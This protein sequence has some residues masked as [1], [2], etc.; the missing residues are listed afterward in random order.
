MRLL[1]HQ[2]KRL[3]AQYGLVFTVA[4]VV[5]TAAGA[6]EAAARIGATVVLK[7]QVPFGGRGKAGAVKVAATP[8][9]AQAA[10]AA[11]LQMT[12]RSHRVTQV[13]VEPKVAIRRELYAGVSWDTSAKLP[14]VLAGL[15]G[16][17]DVEALGAIQRRTFDP[18]AGLSAEA[19]CELAARLGLPAGLVP[20][21]GAVLG[22]LSHAFLD[23][24]GVTVE[25]NPLVETADGALVGLDARVELDD[26]AA[27]RQQARLAP[28][29]PIP[30]GSTGRPPTPLEEEARRIDAT[31]HRGVAGRVVEFDG[32][33][34]LLI[35]GGG[36]SLTV[37][38]AVRRHGG[39]P[40][41]YCEVG[42]NPTEEKVA[43]L[44]ALLLS[45]PG[46]R[47]LAVIMNVVNNTR[48]DVMA[49]GVLMGLER[50]GRPAA[51]TIAVFRIP[52]SWEQEARE[53][54]ARAGVTALGRDV[55]LD[56]AARRAVN[57]AA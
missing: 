14:V 10:A 32:D 36:A 52:G 22:K 1:E 42:G 6:G 28:L 23:C 48:A 15:G 47:K 56:E 21:L 27:A 9:E 13:S 35:G 43:G 3:L 40:A 53:L 7:A 33:L 11:L 18:R 46:V 20:G 25:I 8:A 31:D 24:D 19:G 17:V 50:A 16:G 57:H 26:D 29:G 54:M 45:K 4:D 39:R 44:T 38:D 2:G 55:S 37:F 5:E 41:N 51:G 12:L 34:A 49:R 30:Q